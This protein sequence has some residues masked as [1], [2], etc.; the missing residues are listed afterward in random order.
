[1]P[2]Q[3]ATG[4][5]YDASSDQDSGSAAKPDVAPG[6]HGAREQQE[7]RDLAVGQ[8][9]QVLGAGHLEVVGALDREVELGGPVEPPM[10]VETC[11]HK[12]GRS[13]SPHCGV[14]PNSS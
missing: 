12:N 9:V 11:V 14:S 8:G 1:M 7:Q 3:T 6:E 10:V 2:R 5:R 13:E 4:K